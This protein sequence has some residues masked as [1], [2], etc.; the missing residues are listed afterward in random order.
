MNNSHERDPDTSG[1]THRSELK[2]RYGFE[3]WPGGDSRSLPVVFLPQPHALGGFTHERRH[4]LPGGP[5][6]FLDHLA[7][8]PGTRLALWVQQYNTVRD[9]REG[10][11]DVL[12]LSMAPRLPSCQERGF[13]DVGD[14][15][16]CGVTDPVDVIFFVR[17]NVLLRVESIGDTPVPVWDVAIELDRQIITSL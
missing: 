6:A 3:Q 11:V 12:R 1:D 7:G 5:Q 16:F 10:L 9:A 14:V 8:P 2:Q 4:S 15:C 13:G 17:A